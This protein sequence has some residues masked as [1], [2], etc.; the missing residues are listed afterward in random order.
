MVKV[1]KKVIVILHA[2]P[3]RLLIN[4]AH[5]HMVAQP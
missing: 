2:S 4:L 1:H 3:V 5:L